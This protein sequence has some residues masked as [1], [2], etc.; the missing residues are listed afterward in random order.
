MRALVL[1]DTRAKPDTEQAR[2]EREQD[3]QKVLRQGCAELAEAMLDKLFTPRAS[4]Q[5]RETWHGIMAS[6]PPQGVAAALRA[7][8]AVG[9]T[10]CWAAFLSLAGRVYSQP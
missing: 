2:Q 1:A 6:S 10:R 3:A 7:Q 4:P 9:W 5:L 8:S